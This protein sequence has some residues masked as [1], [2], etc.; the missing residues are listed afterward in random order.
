MCIR[1]SIVG[2]VLAG[3]TAHWIAQRKVPVFVRGLMPV[4]II[5]LGATLVS[6][7]IM[8]VLLAKPLATLMEALTK[9]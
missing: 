3:V 4:V 6:G 8:L 2:G 1:D 9:A 7:L 5:P